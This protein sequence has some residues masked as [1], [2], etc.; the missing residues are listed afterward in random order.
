VPRVAS[1]QNITIDGRFSPAQILIGPNYGIGANLGRQVG[2]NLFH[3][4]GQFGLVAGESA[5]FSGPVT[6]NNVIGR[7][8]G[9]N[10]SSINGQIRSTITGANLYLIKPSGIV[11][12]DP[13]ATISDGIITGPRIE[14]SMNMRARTALLKDRALER[15]II[16]QHGAV[17]CVGVGPEVEKATE[18]AAR[19]GSI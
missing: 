10:A 9:D 19:R 8:T 2:S 18:D 1:A 3:S 14:C 7:V 6:I 11:F 4:F 12:G 16:A 17:H 13:P 5:A 15:P